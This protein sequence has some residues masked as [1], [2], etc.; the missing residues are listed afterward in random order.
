M[1]MPID[2]FRFLNIP[3]TKKARRFSP[4]DFNSH[5]VRQDGRCRFRESSTSVAIPNRLASDRA[6]VFRAGLAAHAVD[7]GF[8]GKLLAFIERAHACAL[9]RADVDE[10]VVAAVIGRDEAKTLG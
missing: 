8:E 3:K 7:L 4:A 2:G 5:F 1:R 6:K 10:H 9:D